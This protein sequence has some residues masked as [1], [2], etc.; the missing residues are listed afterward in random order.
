M[1][2]T[3]NP[4]PLVARIGGVARILGCSA[5][6]IRRRMKNDP[7]F[8]KPWRDSPHGDLQWLITEVESFVARKAAGRPAV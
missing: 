6:T 8:P 7:D 2:S 5:S 1:P 3:E 4:R